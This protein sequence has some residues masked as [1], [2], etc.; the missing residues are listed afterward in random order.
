MNS[1]PVL[2]VTYSR[3]APTAQIGVLKRCLRLI[4]HLPGEIEPHLLHFGKLP[5]EDPEF[6]A[7]RSRLHVHDDR[8]GPS[9]GVP[10]LLTKLGKPCLVLGEA[11]LAGRMRRTYQSAS[12][13]G[14][15]QVGID[16]YYGEFTIGHL[17]ERWPGVERWLLIGLPERPQMKSRFGELV[18]PLTVLPAK[19]RPPPTRNR[20]CILGYDERTLCTGIQL[21]SRLPISTGADVFLQPRSQH[22]FELLRRQLQHA[23]V[24]VT[25]AP[26]DPELFASIARSKFVICKNGFQ[27][28]VECLHLGSPVVC[29]VCPGGVDYELLSDWLR[30]FVHYVRDPHDLGDA[31]LQVMFWMAKSPEIPRT[32]GRADS[33]G[34]RAAARKLL[35]LLDNGLH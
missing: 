23:D 35:Y 22:V 26:S 25:P 14:V 27:Q 32:A 28:I 21:L 7:L 20:V 8:D 5:L 1:R 10:A 29:Q 34:A 16:N 15:R 2:F 12:A 11:P 4:R 24:Q 9:G 33:N 18:V 6:G 3:N 30:P 13:V 17:G 19:F 31:L